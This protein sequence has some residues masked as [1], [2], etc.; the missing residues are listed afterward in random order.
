MTIHMYM[1][2]EVYAP[3]CVSLTV[4]A[5]PSDLAAGGTVAQVASLM[6]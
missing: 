5:D 3:E 1:R 2:K 6:S 4:K